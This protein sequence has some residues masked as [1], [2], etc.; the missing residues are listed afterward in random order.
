MPV[1]IKRLKWKW[2]I[3]IKAFKRFYSCLMGSLFLFNLCNILLNFKHILYFPI[4]AFYRKNSFPENFPALIRQFI[5]IF[6]VGFSLISLFIF[7]CR[8]LVF[9]FQVFK[10]IM[11]FFLQVFPRLYW[12]TSRGIAD[13][14]VPLTIIDHYLQRKSFNQILVERISFLKLFYTLLQLTDF[15]F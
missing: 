2:S 7:L 9:F 15:F 10:Y 11:G 14:Q 6:F 13:Y 5:I 3:F 4:C 12:S 1:F 8:L